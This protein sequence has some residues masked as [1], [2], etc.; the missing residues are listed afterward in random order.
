M[1]SHQ[2]PGQSR[3]HK[4]WAPDFPFRPGSRPFFYGWVIVA[5]ATIGMVFTIPGQTMGFSVFTDTLIEELRLTRLQLSTAYLVGT[6]LSGFSL[7]WLG[8]LFDRLGARR[9]AVYAA[10]ITGA[11]LLYLSQSR[12]ISDG[13]ASLVSG[14]GISHTV[15]AF[16]V[17]TLGFFMIRASAQGVLALTG[18]NMIGKWFDYHRGTA[19]AVSGVITGFS[20]AVAPR[21][22]NDLITRFGYDGAWILLGILT[23]TVMAG[24]AWLL[25]RDNPE[26][27]GMQMDGPQN[28]GKKRT[29][30]ADAI[31]HR[32]FTRSQAMR[33]LPF[34]T[35]TLSFAFYSLF[36]T[37]FTFHVVSIGAEAGIGRTV[38]IGYFLPMAVM[39]VST[40]L[41]VGWISGRT[42]LK[43]LLILMNLAA[44]VAVAG[45]IN[46]SHGWGVILFIVGN[47]ITGGAVIG[48]AGIVVPRFFGRRHM[49]AISG[50][51][52]SSM[53]VASGIGPFI[54]SLSISA[55][56]SYQTVLWISIVIPAVL[57]LL[58]ITSDNP[59]RKFGCP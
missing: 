49:G 22:L 37:A 41:F 7:P 56:G 31:A 6:V 18:R 20:F 34:W 57:A 50:I 5:A 46:L 8:Q 21:I 30:H 4:F 54:F 25:Y 19:L 39:S 45:T 29:L 10:L 52:M 14:M 28:A 55:T 16:S 59:Q 15:V 13:I 53:V 36:V 17:I 33:T 38:V 40:N 51:G 26:Q 12:P 23:I 43:Y 58:S 11:V 27:C 9:I 47:G 2:K 1:Q 3:A 48:L 44:V 42:R 24:I 32:D 35:F